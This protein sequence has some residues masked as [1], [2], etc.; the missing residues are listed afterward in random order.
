MGVAS[1]MTVSLIHDNRLWGLLSCH[2]RTPRYVP[3]SMRGACEL[4][5]SMVVGQLVHKIE[6]QTREEKVRRRA[7]LLPIMQRINED[8][9]VSQALQR[10]LPRL[11]ELFD[12]HGIAIADGEQLTG[13]GKTPPDAGA[14]RD[15]RETLQWDDLKLIGHRHRIDPRP[16][17]VAPARDATDPDSV[18]VL[19]L[20]LK[21]GMDLVLFRSPIDKTLRWGGDPEKAVKVDDNGVGRLQPRESFAEFLQTKRGEAQ[22]WTEADLQLAAELRGLINTFVVRRLEMLAR[23]LK[24]RIR[25]EQELAASELR[26]KLAFE[27]PSLSFWEYDIRSQRISVGHWYG[28][29]GYDPDRMPESLDKLFKLIHPED[30]QQVETAFTA[31]LEERSPSYNTQMRM[32]N[33]EG[34]WVWLESRARMLRSPE[35]KPLSVIG[36]HYDISDIK[37]TQSRLLTKNDELQSLVYAISHDLKSPLV[38]VKGF[39]GMLRDD[40]DE[41]DFDQARHDLNRIQTATESM[42]GVI[43]DLLELSRLGRDGLRRQSLDLAHM[44]HE[45]REDYAPELGKC[46][47]SLELVEPVGELFADPYAIKRTLTNLVDNAIRYACSEPGLTIRVGCDRVES[48]EHGAVLYVRDEG[49]GIEPAYHAKIF[50]VFERLAR[51]QAGSGVGLASVAKA[52]EL[53][54][55]RAWVESE[56]GKGAVFKVFVPYP[57]GVDA[58]RTAGKDP[59]P[60]DR[61]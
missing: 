44:V 37:D 52:A 51:D 22:E 39:V 42:T 56:F 40:L 9:E 20:T 7:A 57:P 45:L 2:H 16:P 23:N 4:L 58:A 8:E 29:L 1:T 36:I 38:T 25:M 54:E 15:L 48:P 13:H 3:Y 53:H 50:Q 60:P 55:G 46:G 47:A 34:R 12:A 27:I 31:Y 10:E 30:R 43:D 28:R 61:P 41:G 18:G 19:Y 5:G 35:G 14:L 32:R 6:Q 17:G 33:A 49:R 26:T 59:G 11:M 24:S 21:P